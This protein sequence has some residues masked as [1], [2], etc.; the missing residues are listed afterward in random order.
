M[1]RKRETNTETVEKIL[2]LM[3]EQPA[4]SLMDVNRDTGQEMW[5]ALDRIISAENAMDRHVAK[6]MYFDKH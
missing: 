6:E 5:Q 2:R 3:R 1:Y 4:I